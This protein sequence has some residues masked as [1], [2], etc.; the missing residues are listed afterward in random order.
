MKH[1][2]K[3]NK[4]ILHL[5]IQRMQRRKQR[6]STHTHDTHKYIT[7][8]ACKE[9]AEED[10]IHKVN[11]RG[12]YTGCRGEC[13]GEARTRVQQYKKEHTEDSEDDHRHKD[14]RKGRIQ[15]MG[16]RIQGRSIHTN[17]D[18]PT[19][20]TS[21]CTD[22][23]TH[24]HARGKH[25][26]NTKD[27]EG[28]AEEATHTRDTQRRNTQDAEENAEEERTHKDNTKET[29]KETAE[30]NTGEGHTQG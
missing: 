23:C 14:I 13:R 9:S 28:K 29:A 25:M 18:I 26:D 21:T 11:T 30:E 17:A 24:T 22:T 27:V 15:R 5:I 19:P 10:H 4:R 20:D 7:K 2:W 8:G 3:T 16:R 1:K 12:K 6:R